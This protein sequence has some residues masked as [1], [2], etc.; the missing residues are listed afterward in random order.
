MESMK[1]VLFE[2]PTWLLVILAVVE[3]AIFW[4]WLKRR[5]KRS[6]MTLLIPPILA[7]LLLGLAT[8]VV[9]DREQIQSNL[10]QIA[11]D[12]QAGRLDAAALY[13]DDAYEGFGGDKQSLLTIARTTRGDHPIRSIRVTRLEVLVQ[14]RRAEAQITTVVHLEDSMGGGAYSFAWTIDWGKFDAGWRI[15]H[16]SN[17]ETVIPGFEPGKRKERE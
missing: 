1:H 9:T 12:Y 2:N 5:T 11:D 16:I 14:G 4:Y 10:Q 17:P 6:A 7:G 8:L 15:L 3:L 13:L